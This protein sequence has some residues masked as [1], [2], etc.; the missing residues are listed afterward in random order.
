[1]ASRT[2]GDGRLGLSEAIRSLEVLSVC[3][4]RLQR[5]AGWRFARAKRQNVR[6]PYATMRAHASERQQ[7]DVHPSPHK[8]AGDAQNARRVFGRDLRIISKHGH[9][10]ARGKLVEKVGKG[11]QGRRRERDCFLRS[12]GPHETDVRPRR[13]A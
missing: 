3:R 9:T 5:L 10:I 6:E 12:I 4:Q 7:A 1:L 11:W 13:R 8:R 2:T